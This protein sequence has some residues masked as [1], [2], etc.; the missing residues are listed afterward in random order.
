MA[1]VHGAGAVV[2][3]D[4]DPLGGFVNNTGH[5]LNA[6]SHDVTTYGKTAHVFKAGL[7]G[8][9][10]T[11]TGIYDDG[12]TGPKA[13]LEPLVGGAAVPMTWRPEGTGSG[14]PETVVDVLVLKYTETDPVADMITWACDLQHSDAPDFTAQS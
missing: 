14:K 11:L 4:G 13:V 6:D 7:K 8:G 12:A 1:F 2:L 5:E 10:T 9:T 3:I